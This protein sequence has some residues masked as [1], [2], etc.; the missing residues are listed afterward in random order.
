MIETC[1]LNILVRLDLGGVRDRNM[2]PK[3]SGK[4]GFKRCTCYY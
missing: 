1:V 2:C 4:I 3:Y